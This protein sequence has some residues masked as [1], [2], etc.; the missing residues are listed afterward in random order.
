MIETYVCHTSGVIEGA[1]PLPE[2]K[3]N[4]LRN[5]VFMLWSLTR[6]AQQF[7]PG[8]K[9]IRELEVM[10]YYACEVT[11][12]RRKT[13]VD[14]PKMIADWKVVIVT[15]CSAHDK[16]DIDKA[17]FRMDELLKPMLNAPVAQIR[18][19]YA[20]LLQALSDDK[21]V[22]FFIWSLFKS[23]GE[24][25]LEKADDKAPPQRLRKKL[26]QEVAHLAMTSQTQKDLLDAMVGALMWRSPEALKEIKD[27]LEA[28]AKPRV[29]GRESCLFLVA[30]RK[31]GREH[32]VML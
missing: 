8:F 25:V 28:G 1:P 2:P 32:T 26:A 14:V 5:E 3:K 15:L 27:D 10:T 20:G 12:G 6:L 13:P 11:S 7:G 29:Q 4:N 18:E 24:T 23:W 9:K 16:E 21:A 17:E 22:P 31:G 30:Q 19:F